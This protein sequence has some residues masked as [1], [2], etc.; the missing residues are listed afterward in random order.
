MPTRSPVNDPGPAMT[1]KRS[2]SAMDLPCR[3]SQ[4]SDVVRQPLAVRARGI[5]RRRLAHV[6]VHQ[7][8]AARACDRLERQHEHGAML[9]SDGFDPLRAR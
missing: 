5:A 3:A 4:S 6:A 7:G 1:A 8:D 9:Y 2:T